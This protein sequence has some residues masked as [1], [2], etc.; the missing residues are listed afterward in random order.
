MVTANGVIS[1]L[2]SLFRQH[3]DGVHVTWDFP[4]SENQN[5]QGLAYE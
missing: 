4:D 2:M 5:K 3:V 1:V